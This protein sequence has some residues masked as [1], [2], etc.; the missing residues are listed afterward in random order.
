MAQ[1]K[2]V[3]L[4]PR[5]GPKAEV[6]EIQLL[7]GIG[8]EGDFHA[9]GGPRQ[10][11]LL[12]EE[13][14][15]KMKAKGLQLENGAFGENIIVRGIELSSFKIGSSLNI[16][17]TKVEITKIGKE[18]PEH[19]LIYY[20]TGDC[21]MPREGVFAKVLRSGKVKAGDNLEAVQ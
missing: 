7:A 1:V 4:S 18:C 20:Q 6:K 3:C 16:G 19:C 9:Q 14:I 11:S 12:T 8:V 13:S 17:E 5:K 15:E 2:A 10:V 21:I